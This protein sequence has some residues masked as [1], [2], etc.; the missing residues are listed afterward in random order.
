M[1]PNASDGEDELKEITDLL[2]LGEVQNVGPPQPQPSVIAPS[3]LPS[4]GFKASGSKFKPSWPS[5]SISQTSSGPVRSVTPVTEVGRSSPKMPSSPS[6][7]DRVIERGAPAFGEDGGQPNAH[8]ADTTPQLSSID[9]VP[10]SQASMSSAHFQL[11]LTSNI[12]MSPSFPPSSNR[13]QR[14]PKVMSALVQERT[15]GD[16]EASNENETR[17]ERKVSRFMAGRK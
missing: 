17:E 12:V 2:K 10:H 1:D 8:K 13:P 7:H 14:P 16:P 4:S 3:A 15:S 11:P 9:D 5:S 6:I